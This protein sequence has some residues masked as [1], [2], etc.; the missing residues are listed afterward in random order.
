MPEIKRV[1]NPV[2]RSLSDLTRRDFLEAACKAHS[3][4][5][6][7]ETQEWLASIDRIVDF[8][9]EEFHARQL[10]LLCRVGSQVIEPLIHTP[11]NGAS[12]GPFNAATTTDLS[13]LSGFGVYR[14][15]EDGKVYLITKSEHYHA[16]LGHSFPGYAL[17]QTARELGIENP[18]HN[19]TRGWITRLLEERLVCEANGL[20]WQDQ[21]GLHQVLNK[22]D[23]Y[24]LNRV[25]NLET[26]S[27]AAEAA[28][29][30]ILAR[31]YSVQPRFDSP[32][33]EGR[34][35]VILVVGN[36]E[37]G[38]QANYHGTTILT[39]TM[40]G[41]W[42][43]LTRRMDQSGILKIHS[44]RPNCEQDLEIAFR[45]FESGNYKIAGFFHEIVMMNYGALLLTPQFLRKAHDLCRQHDVPTVVD[46][47]QS[48]MWAP[49]LFLYK[50]YGLNP[51]F[52]ALGKGFSGGEYSASRILFS[53]AFDNLPQF[54][55][56]VTNGQEELASLSYLITMAWAKENA[57]ITSQVGEYYERR[58]KDMA[59]HHADKLVRIEGNRHL[60]GLR[61]HD[62]A[63][64]R[65]FVS[66]LT[67]RGLDL[68]VQTYK[69]DTPPVVLTKLPLIVD[70][71]MVDFIVE[72]MDTAMADI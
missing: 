63:T 51:S 5:T 70:E 46:E 26:G 29:K 50:E 67:E 56:L 52:V 38:T 55:A 11:L 57:S 71:T 13:P 61:F 15:G 69:A 68:S 2:H 14:I 33:H 22:A 4:L 40:R 6:G 44:I 62:L 10:E 23:P 59:G 65:K 8:Y 16:S 9:P 45:D 47:I 58:L 21:E 12:T 20:D 53:S 17:L 31:F 27:L 25:L 41:M 66:R 1:F 28:L 37:G 19:N 7:T 72:L 60:C 49:D 24:I 43:E 32:P 36:D 48:C 18:T 34:I 3:T 35:P 42:P 39:Q 54:G 64:A 30:M